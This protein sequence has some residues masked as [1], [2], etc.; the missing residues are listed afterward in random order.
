MSVFWGTKTL[1]CHCTFC[2]F[3]CLP[4]ADLVLH[5]WRRLAISGFI[6]AWGNGHPFT[7][8]PSPIE[9]ILEI[10]LKDPPMV[11]ENGIVCYWGNPQNSTSLSLAFDKRAWFHPPSS[12]RLTWFAV[13]RLL[14]EERSKCDDLKLRELLREK[15]QAD[16]FLSFVNRGNAPLRWAVVKLTSNLLVPRPGCSVVAPA[17]EHVVKVKT[18]ATVVKLRLQAKSYKFQLD[19]TKKYIQKTC[20]LKKI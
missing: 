20:P 1:P 12:E 16:L 13:P 4:F 2:L 8:K 11:A 15:R 18:S 9:V 17:M 10:I 7:N 3:C 14:N 19:E 6:C 5:S